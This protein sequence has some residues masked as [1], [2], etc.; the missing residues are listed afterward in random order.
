MLAPGAEAS[1]ADS[2]RC[3]TCGA[4]YSV[5]VKGIGCPV[6]LLRRTLDTEY[7][8]VTDG[9]GEL[10]IARPDGRFD[11]YEISLREDGSW[12]EL[13][14]GA[15]GVTYRAID[16]V[17]GSSV[18]LKVIAVNIATHPEARQR[19]LREARMAAQLRHPNVASVFYYGIRQTDGQCFYVM[20]LVEGETAKARVA[21]TG[22]L[23]IK[24]AFRNPRAGISRYRRCRNSRLG[25]PGPE[26]GES[27]AN[28]GR[29]ADSQNHRF[30]YGE[31]GLG[32]N[33]NG[34][35]S[36]RNCWDACLRQS[37]TG[38]R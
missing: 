26:T 11:H 30:R 38:Q 21:R 23:P 35:H 17:L 33:G 20:E 10:D 7:S 29:G 25:A 12:D 9:T 16:K 8:S 5:Q 32:G 14:R 13:G 31:T 18:A 34:H 37:G 15:M 28:Q 27:D 2:C 4:A 3:P 19:F 24:L 6:C 22:P 1:G 36:R